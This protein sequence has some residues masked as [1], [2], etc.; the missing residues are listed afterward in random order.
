MG[1]DGTRHTVLGLDVQLG[2]SVLGVHRGLGQ[3]TDSRSFDH[4]AD[5]VALDGLV[6]GDAASTVQAANRVD[7]AT[8]VL[9]ASSVSSLG[10]LNRK[11][12][13]GSVG[14]N[15]EKIGMDGREGDG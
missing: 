11:I 15:I 7:V 4:V 12:V 3:V 6:L 1:V 5:N 2:N 9:G 14:R 8:A 10:G 13:S